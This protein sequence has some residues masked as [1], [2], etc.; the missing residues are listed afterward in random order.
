MLAE[1]RAIAGQLRAKSGSAP[2]VA[3]Q[4]GEKPL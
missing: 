4:T 3:T 2:K 1:E